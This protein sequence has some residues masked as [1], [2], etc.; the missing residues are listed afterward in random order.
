MVVIEI[1]N[2][3]HISKTNENYKSLCICLTILNQ[4]MEVWRTIDIRYKVAL[5]AKQDYLNGKVQNGS[6]KKDC[7]CTNTEIDQRKSSNKNL[8]SAPNETRR[9]ARAHRFIACYVN[10]YK[11]LVSLIFLRRD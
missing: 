11:I 8:S 3:V 1:I 7:K 6:T 5:V 9:C 2:M 4:G 10:V